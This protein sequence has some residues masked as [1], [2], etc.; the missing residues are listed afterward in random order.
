[1]SESLLSRS[2]FISKLLRSKR[3]RDGYVYEHVRNGIPFQIRAL[4]NE[5]EWTQSDLGE[6]AKKPRTVITRLEDPNYG[7]LSLK[8]LFEIAS[9]FDVALL[10]KFVPFSRLVREYEDVSWQALGAK[11]VTDEVEVAKL[12]AWG[13]EA[14]MVEPILIAGSGTGKTAAM[15][16]GAL[17]STSQKAVVVSAPKSYIRSPFIHRGEATGPDMTVIGKTTKAA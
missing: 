4:R 14:T 9:G 1:M 5:R 13:A 8:T 11:S 2:N 16:A 15:A 7:K 10:V 6:A 12:K 3:F 17:Q